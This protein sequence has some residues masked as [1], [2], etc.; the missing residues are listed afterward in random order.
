MAPLSVLPTF[1]L[2]LFHDPASPES[3]FALEALQM[4]CH[5]F[6]VRRI[7][8]G[9]TAPSTDELRELAGR[10]VGDKV[11]ALVRRGA[12]YERLGID[13]DGADLEQVLSTLAEHPELL[14]TPILD[15]GTDVMIGHP[16]ERAEAWAIAGHVIDARE[17]GVSVLRAA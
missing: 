17:G 10:L 2:T 13:V 5:Q 7:D 6:D 15:D 11:D 8:L 4:G 16:I 1:P 9:S 14:Q 12:S 3:E